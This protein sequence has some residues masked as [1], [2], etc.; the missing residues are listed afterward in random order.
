MYEVERKYRLDHERVRPVLAERAAEQV[1]ALLQRDIYFQ[2]PVRDFS[3]TDEALRLRIE[4]PMDNIDSESTRLTYKGPRMEG[5]G[6][7]REE[8]ETVVE[9]GKQT[10][11]ILKGLGCRKVATVKKRRTEYILDDCR[12]CLDDVENLGEFVE[13]EAITNSDEID[14]AL[15][16]VEQ[17]E[18]SL[19]RDTA[20]PVEATY[21]EMLLDE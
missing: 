16:Q 3:E 17:L 1:S 6:K 5:Q 10:L 2:H 14:L 15:N 21:L 11:D 18:R 8:F 12:V 9:D 4:S 20:I 7:V 13:I 19:G